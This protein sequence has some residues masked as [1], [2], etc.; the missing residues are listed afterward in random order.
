MSSMNQ[1]QDFHEHQQCRR[2]GKKISPE[3]KLSSQADRV[4][5]QL[6]KLRKGK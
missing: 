4:M 5:P 3:K 1:E 6:T 2:E